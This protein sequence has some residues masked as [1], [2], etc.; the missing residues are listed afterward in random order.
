MFEEQSPEIIAQVPSYRFGGGHA[1]H[2]S[3]AADVVPVLTSV[4]VMQLNLQM[5]NMDLNIR[6][7][8]KQSVLNAKSALKYAI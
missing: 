1:G 8:I 5:M 2:H 3:V 4:L 7:L 6:I